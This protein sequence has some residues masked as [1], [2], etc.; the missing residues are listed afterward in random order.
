[1]ARNGRGQRPKKSDSKRGNGS[2][3]AI[4]SDLEPGIISSED[5]DGLVLI[6]EEE[7]L[8]R[9]VYLTLYDKWKLHVF[10]NIA[11]SEETHMELMEYLIERYKLEDPIPQMN[12]VTRGVYSNDELTTLYTTLVEKG[13]T[14][15]NAALEVGAT[16]ED[17]DIADI[18]TLLEKTA[19]EDI[20]IVYQNLLK[21]SRNH[22][23]SFIRQLE[24]RDEKYSPRYISERDFQQIIKSRNE[25]GAIADPYFRY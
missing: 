1:M 2:I 23:R 19:A 17:L 24:G 3:E 25:T 5:K 8:A 11:A 20:K 21:G 13:L 6:R 4:L 7:K 22:L 14:S 12:L 10:R 15:L 16:V 9:D 18:Q